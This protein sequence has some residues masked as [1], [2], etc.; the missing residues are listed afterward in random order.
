[1]L[2]DIKPNIDQSNAILEPSCMSADWWESFLFKTNSMQDTKV[3][4]DAFS[5]REIENLKMLLFSTIRRIYQ[6]KKNDYGFRCYLNG[7]EQN[8]KFVVKHLSEGNP[9]EDEN[10]DEWM[11]RV[12][13]NQGISIIFNHL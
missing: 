13:E 10:L 8:Q 4:S 12:L 7:V 2:H 3:F 6:V 1:M 5:G 9:C 11:A